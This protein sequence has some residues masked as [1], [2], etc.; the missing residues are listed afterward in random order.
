MW[1]GSHRFGAVVS[2]SEI[3]GADTTPKRCGGVGGSNARAVQGTH[4]RHRLRSTANSE[5]YAAYG[6]VYFF[7]SRDAPPGFFL[8]FVEIIG[9]LTS[10]VAVP[11]RMQNFR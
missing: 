10:A 7:F 1:F 4:T 9:E 11:F 8:A 6:V 2:V 3:S 5:H